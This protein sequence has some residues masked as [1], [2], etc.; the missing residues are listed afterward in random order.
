MHH[1][2]QPVITRG[3]IDIKSRR[4]F[5]ED[6]PKKTKNNVRGIDLALINEAISAISDGNATINGKAPDTRI[7]RYIVIS[8]YFITART[9]LHM[10]FEGP[11]DIQDKCT[12]AIKY[13]EKPFTYTFPEITV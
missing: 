9:P 13:R 2:T 3:T 11:G 8:S 12:V 10:F 6:L 1:P 5:V 4:E 7:E